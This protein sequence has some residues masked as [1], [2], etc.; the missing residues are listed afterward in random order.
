MVLCNQRVV[1]SSSKSSVLFLHP[2]QGMHVLIHPNPLLLQIFQ[3]TSGKP[4]SLL[5]CCQWHNLTPKHPLSQQQICNGNKTQISVILSLPYTNTFWYP[6]Q[7]ACDVYTD[8]S[9]CKT[10]TLYLRLL[11][12]LSKELYGTK[13]QTAVATIKN[14]LYFFRTGISVAN[15]PQSLMLDNMILANTGKCWHGRKLTLPL[16]SY[17][18]CSVCSWHTGCLL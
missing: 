14:P 4:A 3:T 11:L 9:V 15:K 13:D 12:P 1:Q 10:S 5:L 18:T 2:P 6:T 7:C 16:P 8:S 17:C